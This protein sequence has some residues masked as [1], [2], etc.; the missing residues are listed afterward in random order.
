LR[1]ATTIYATRIVVGAL[2]LAVCAYLLSA[3][4]RAPEAWTLQIGAAGDNRFSTGFFLREDSDGLPFRWSS[5]DAR[6]VLHGADAS[7]L[8]IELRINGSQ[9]VKSGD[10]HFSIVAEQPSASGPISSTFAVSDGWQRY[11]VLLPPSDAQG[12]APSYALV[13]GTSRP[14]PQ[15]GRDLGAAL[16][17]VRLLPIEESANPWWLQGL[18]F[19]PRALFY[20]WLVAVIACAVGRGC[21]LLAAWQS[22]AQSRSSQSAWLIA[23]LVGLLATIGLVAW[24]RLAPYTL[25]SLLPPLPWFLTVATVGLLAGPALQLLSQLLASL[26]YQ[27]PLWAGAVLLLLAQGLFNAQTALLGAI[28]LMLLALSLIV[29]AERKVS[30]EHERLQPALPPVKHPLWWLAGIFVLALGLRF[31]DLGNLP[32]GLWRDEARH[33]LYALRILE[34]SSYRPIYIA[35][36]GV[37]MPSLTFYFFALEFKLWGIHAWT[38]RPLTALA[39]ALSVLPLYGLTRR[40]FSDRIALL[41]ALLYASSAWH[42]TVSRFSF[43][44]AFDP[45]FGLTGVWLLVEGWHLL[46]RNPQERTNQLKNALLWLISG[47]FVG[48]AIQTYHTG[49]VVPGVAGLLALGLLWQIWYDSRKTLDKGPRN[50]LSKQW[51]I[52][53]V[54]LGLG[55]LISAGPMF[56]YA[57]TKEAEFNDRVSGVFLLS[58][59]ALKGGSALAALDT[60]LGKHLLLYNVR[61][62]ENGRHAPPNRPGFDFVSGF[63]LLLGCALIARR[64]PN[65]TWPGLGWRGLFLI[66]AIG[67]SMVPSAFAV[68]APHGMRSV[69]SIAFACIVAALGLEW[70][71]RLLLNSKLSLPKP[72]LQA[73]AATVVLLVVALNYSTYFVQMRE[74]PAVWVSFYPVHTKVGEYVRQIRQE[75]PDRQIFVASGIATNPVFVYL[76]HGYNIQTFDAGVASEPLRPGAI[77]ILSGYTYEKDREV[78]A[79]YLGNDPQPLASG[80][81]FPD[82]RSPSF[83]V[84]AADPSAIQP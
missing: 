46:K 29:V 11:R 47:V 30:N 10:P 82:G 83:V 4:L 32:F 79:N 7:P 31:Y 81:D 56:W 40:L 9:I 6:L 39:G 37:N 50:D 57:L 27:Y 38:M 22:G 65:G 48:L 35:E 41:A 28:L 74:D 18:P 73:A 26:P 21:N 63:G 76:N 20:T 3:A 72:I 49:R 59:D 62:D 13:S 44:T 55:V 52:S 36:G 71:L 51:L 33:G 78:L 5:P 68:D 8:A 16:S 2:L 61:G 84:Y 1:N 42:I 54:A 43:S 66:G 77:F 75:D 70:F 24:A 14:G 67:I 80:I 19:H 17:T 34:D 53:V 64:A 45:L 25:A 15:D 60:T 58:E 69:G 12:S 23:A